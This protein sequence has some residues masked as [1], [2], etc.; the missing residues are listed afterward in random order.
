MTGFSFKGYETEKLFLRL[1]ATALN[2]EKAPQLPDDADIEGLFELA[3]KQN[4]VP[5]IYTALNSMLEPPRGEMWQKFQKCFLSDCIRSEIQTSEYGKLTEYLCKNGVK[6]LPLKGIVLKEL[7]AFPYLRVM[8]DVDML[9]EGVTSKEL[10]LL[11][12]AVDYSSEQL[13]KWAHDVFCKKPVMNVEMHRML[14]IESSPYRTILE[15]MFAK[16]EPDADTTNLYHMH[17]EDLYLHLL[18]HGAKHFEESGLGVRTLSDIYVVNQRFAAS[19]DEEYIARQLDSVGL[20][21]FEQKMRGMALTLFGDGKEDISESDF[22]FFFRGGQYGSGG[23]DWAYMNGGG[24]TRA[25][26]LVNKL[27]K[28]YDEMCVLYPFLKKAPVL[29]PVFWIYR[30]FDVLVNRRKAIAPTLKEA[31]KINPENV[32][33]AGQIMDD[34]GLKRD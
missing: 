4:M 10:S 19:W 24:K 11:M 18:T 1:V 5:V 7:Y 31:G 2:E 21:A 28:P 30:Y 6:L 27:F 13:D 20:S 3:S 8:T 15:G 29:L 26:Y 16:A 14:V 23:K 32:S 34:F 22:S 25:G 33:Y 9:Y 17:S 12:E